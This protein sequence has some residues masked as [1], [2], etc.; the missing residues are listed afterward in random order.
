VSFRITYSVLRTEY[1]VLVV[2]AASVVT[3]GGC[4]PTATSS[5][6]T[7]P[8]SGASLSPEN[9]KLT[10]A[11]GKSLDELIASH[12]GQVVLVD[13]W[14]TW[15]GPCVQNFPHTVELAKKYRDKGLAT[16]AVSF[17]VLDDEPKVREFLAKQGADFEN[18]ISKH[19]AIG[20]KPAE[21]FDVGPLPEYRLY[22]RQGKLSQKW[23]GQAEEIGKLA[24]KIE[25]L[26]A[27]KP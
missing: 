7:P 19:N 20:Q 9:V 24:A 16:I 8:G 1:I 26:L 21:D 6:T 14:A 25:E 11:D 2:M 27:A 10:Q 12:K 3:S 13:Y 17:D 15:C 22:D 5:A 23:E 18:L 4:Q